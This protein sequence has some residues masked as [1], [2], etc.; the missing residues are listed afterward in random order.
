M[1]LVWIVP[2]AYKYYYRVSQKNRDYS[3]QGSFSGVKWP[4]IKKWNKIDPH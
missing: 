3:V 1:V 2:T 4:Q